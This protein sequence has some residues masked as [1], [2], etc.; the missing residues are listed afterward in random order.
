ME[1]IQ[2]SLETKAAENAA[3][4]AAEAA[5]ATEAKLSGDTPK[6]KSVLRKRATNGALLAVADLEE[7]VDAA[8]PMLGEEVGKVA[9]AK[10]VVSALRGKYT[11]NEFEAT[12]GYRPTGKPRRFRRIEPLRERFVGACKAEGRSLFSLATF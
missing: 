5:A 4:A 3:A 7:G 2:E 9:S 8:P 1:E 6:K 11:T 10:K 12:V